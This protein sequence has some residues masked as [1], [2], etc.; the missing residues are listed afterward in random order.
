[1]AVVGLQTAIWSNRF[2]TLLLVALFPLLLFGVIFGVFFFQEYKQVTQLSNPP[3]QERSTIS[4]QKTANSSTGLR[5]LMDTATI[6]SFLGPV[7][8]VWVLISFVFHR[9]FIFAF[10]GATPITRKEYPEIYNIVENL[11]ISRGL[12]SPKI[13][14][15]EDES[16][17]AFAVGWNPKDAWIVF[18]RGIL[19]KLSKEEIEAVAGHELTHIMNRD[20]LLMIV[21]IVFIGAIAGI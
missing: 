10:T 13:G 18:S 14:I 2:K 1:M 6:F 9:Q 16:L 20:G 7:L 11:C 4:N 3:A 21:I 15:L 12:P 8:L 17:N 19:E 5:A